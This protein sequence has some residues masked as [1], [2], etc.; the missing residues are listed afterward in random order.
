MNRL[1]LVFV[2]TCL[3]LWAGSS[4][5]CGQEEAPA[6]KLNRLNPTVLLLQNPSTWTELDCSEDQQAKLRETVTAFQARQAEIRKASSA[7]PDRYLAQLITALEAFKADVLD[8]ILLPHQTRRF[9]QIDLQM[10][11]RLTGGSPGQLAAGPLSE[12]LRL[13]ARQRQD[14][15]RKETAAA[16]EISRIQAESQRQIEKVREEL[17]AELRKILSADQLAELEDS[18]GSPAF[19]NA[20]HR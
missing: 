1:K 11:L 9:E 20:R 13:T 10:Q 8:E 5:V 15:R 18:I 16:A 7:D 14:I 19:E 3:S 2:S 4:L 17:Q 6:Q 12:K